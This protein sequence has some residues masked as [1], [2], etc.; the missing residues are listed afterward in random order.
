M[1]S[2]DAMS[3]K[4]RKRPVLASSPALGDLFIQGPL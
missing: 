1:A 4:K 2:L 3:L